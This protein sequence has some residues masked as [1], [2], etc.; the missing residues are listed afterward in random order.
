MLE[1]AEIEGMWANVVYPQLG[2]DMILVQE[3]VKSQGVESPSG[4]EQVEPREA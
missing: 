2:I 1:L 4:G 3:A